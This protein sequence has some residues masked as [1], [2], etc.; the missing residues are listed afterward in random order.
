[1]EAGLSEREQ[2]TVRVRSLE[3]EA[4]DASSAV[5]GLRLAVDALESQNATLQGASSNEP[6]E[7]PEGVGAHGVQLAGL[8]LLCPQPY[9]PL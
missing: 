2:L 4:R 5:T 9:P 6:R 1:M 8:R 3:G 7:P